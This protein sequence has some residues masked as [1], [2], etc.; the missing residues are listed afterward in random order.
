MDYGIKKLARLILPNPPRAHDIMASLIHSTTTGSAFPD[1]GVSLA[2]L[3]SIA[4]SPDFDIPNNF[5][6]K[7]KKIIKKIKIK[8]L[9][10]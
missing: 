8:D 1:I 2:F 6:F 7:I 3:V 4:E 9:Y 5:D 10:F